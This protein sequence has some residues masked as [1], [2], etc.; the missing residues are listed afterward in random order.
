ML[1]I[2]RV[3][4][5]HKIFRKLSKFPILLL[6]LSLLHDM[7]WFYMGSDSS[8][9]FHFHPAISEQRYNSYTLLVKCKHTSLSSLLQNK[10]MQLCWICD[11]LQGNTMLVQADSPSSFHAFSTI[12]RQSDEGGGVFYKA[13]QYYKF[14][15]MPSMWKNNFLAH[16]SC[17]YI[18]FH[19]N[20]VRWNRGIHQYNDFYFNYAIRL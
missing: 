14:E 15:R 4:Q 13:K 11:Y 19:R 6:K 9:W 2:Q 3:N 18:L 1:L 5:Y 20:K 17:S 10:G 16:S 7:N 12:T 8:P